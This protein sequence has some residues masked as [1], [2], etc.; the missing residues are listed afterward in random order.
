MPDIHLKTGRLEYRFQI[1]G[2]YTVIKGDSGSGK[3]TFYDIV[4]AFERDPNSVQNYA[5]R[6]IAAIPYN[7]REGSLTG[8]E[9]YIL[10]AD[11][12]CSLFR[13]SDAP[14]ILRKCLW[15]VRI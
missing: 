15:L 9:D 12:S 8:F 10:V 3:T 1:S 14:S 13:R 11:E 2:K 4:A 5:Y 7:F 6:K